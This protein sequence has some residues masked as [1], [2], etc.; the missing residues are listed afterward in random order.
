MA[1][2]VSDV[3]DYLGG[4]TVLSRELGHRWPT[5]VQGWKSRGVIPSRQI[6]NV[7]AAAK[8]L[9]KPLEAS[10]F[11]EA[12]VESSAAGGVMEVAAQ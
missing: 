10:D 9:N 8:R 2:K 6:P 3:I 1:R 7:L 12:A 5:T 11:F 4:V